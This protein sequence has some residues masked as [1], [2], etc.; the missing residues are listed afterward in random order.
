M[1]SPMERV[2]V[3]LERPWSTWIRRLMIRSRRRQSLMEYT[4]TMMIPAPGLLPAYS[5]TT[6][7]TN[8]ALYTASNA[9]YLQTVAE[10]ELGHTIGLGDTYLHALYKYDL[11]QIMGY[12][13]DINDLNRDGQVDLGSGDK[14]GVSTLY[15]P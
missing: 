15:S 6:N 4:I 5:W 8:T 2:W 12:Y 1:S 3:S 13:N 11:A 10:H 9:F 14:N 7:P